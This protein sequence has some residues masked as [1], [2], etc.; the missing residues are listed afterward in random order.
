MSKTKVKSKTKRKSIVTSKT[1]LSEL[2]TLSGEYRGEYDIE[3]I[4]PGAWG[5][6]KPKTSLVSFNRTFSNEGQKD[7]RKKV[8]M[9]GTDAIRGLIA[10]VGF[11]VEIAY[12]TQGE[13]PEHIKKQTSSDRIETLE[14]SIDK[15][16]ALLAK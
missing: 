15:L 8:F 4:S 2:I 14:R 11:L 5:N 1:T 12:A 13:T 9:C 3:L 10:Q 6:D 16:H 7:Y